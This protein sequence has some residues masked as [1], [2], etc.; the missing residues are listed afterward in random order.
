L[1]QAGERAGWRSF[2]VV[3]NNVKEKIGV[4]DDRTPVS[5]ECEMIR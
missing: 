5:G 1:R 2:F 3:M 4:K